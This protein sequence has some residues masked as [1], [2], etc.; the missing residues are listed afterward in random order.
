M[1]SSAQL[2]ASTAPWNDHDAPR[3]REIATPCTWLAPANHPAGA[4]RAQ[5]TG[6]THDPSANTVGLL[7]L[8][9][10][11]TPRSMRRG[12]DQ[13]G[14]AVPLPSATIAHTPNSRSSRLA[15]L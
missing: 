5:V 2:G 4:S 13:R 1:P 6:S 10:K 9:A 15:R 14:V 12:A 8:K 11:G 3:S 7:S